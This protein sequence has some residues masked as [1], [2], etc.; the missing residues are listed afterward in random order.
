[1]EH[2]GAIIMPLI[3]GKN[4]LSRRRK[5][6]CREELSGFHLVHGERARKNVGPGIRN[7]KEFQKALYG[8]VF[9]GH[10]VHCNEYYIR[11]TQNTESLK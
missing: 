6:V 9:S 7:A 4:A 11:F 8:S 5:P 1:V 3:S 10:T 2:S